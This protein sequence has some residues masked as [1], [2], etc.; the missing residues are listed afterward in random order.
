M[1][2]A[3]LSLAAMLAET[4][5]T[6]AQPF[7]TP[8]ALLEAFYE[9]YFSGSF[10]DDDSIFRSESL[11]ELYDT[12][13]ENT[14]EGE[15]GALSFDPFVDGQDYQITDFAIGPAEID[16]DAA[17]VDVEFN[18]FGEPRTLTYELVYEDDGW[19]IND[20]ISTSPANPYRLREIFA[21]AGE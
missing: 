5:A 1:R 21:E 20:V 18:N 16:G 10:A 14:P 19:R 9:P 7:P 2:L 8:E 11:Q 15:M 12:D 17:T 6:S 4:A 3:A 13:A